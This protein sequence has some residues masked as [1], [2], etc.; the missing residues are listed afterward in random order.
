MILDVKGE[1]LETPEYERKIGKEKEV[2]KNWVVD[3]YSCVHFYRKSIIW[4][5]DL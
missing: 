2:M 5:N 4:L 1:S 3:N